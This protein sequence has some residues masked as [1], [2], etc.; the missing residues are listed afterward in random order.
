MTSTPKLP[1]V[2]L[3]IPTYNRADFI[4][5]TLKSAVSQVPPFNEII[6]IDD[7]SIDDTSAIVGQ[8]DFPIKYHRVENGGVQQA[9][10]IGAELATSEWLVFC[11]SDDLLDI[12]YMAK[13]L[14]YLAKMPPIDVAYVNFRNFSDQGQ[15]PDKLSLCPFDYLEGSKNEQGV[16]TEIPQLLIRNFNFQPFFFSGVA[17]SKNFYFKLNGFDQTLRGVGAEDW[18]FTLRAI[19]FGRIAMFK[20]VLAYVRRHDRNDSSDSLKMLKGEIEIIR[21]FKNQFPL[22]GRELKAC[23][24]SLDARSAGVANAAFSRMNFEDVK[25][26]TTLGS[27]RKGGLILLTKYFV[28]CSPSWL[29]IHIWSWCQRV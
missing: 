29:R 20:D 25:L 18:D 3:V 28:A 11:D 7:G 16:A 24:I 8:I 15:R 22:R 19:A 26:Y 6:V 2:S 12:Q 21:K 13:V 4:G 5:E 10:N 27:L 9:R 14:T 1:T 17:V 23:Q